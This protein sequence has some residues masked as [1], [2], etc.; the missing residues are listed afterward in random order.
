VGRDAGIPQTQLQSR[1]LKIPRQDNRLPGSSP[2]Q[3]HRQATFCQNA[4]AFTNPEARYVELANRLYDEVYD[5]VCSDRFQRFKHI[6]TGFHDFALMYVL[7]QRVNYADCILGY[8]MPAG[9]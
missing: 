2:I 5:I 1:T 9:V 8:G 7:M 6:Y 3:P 4:Y